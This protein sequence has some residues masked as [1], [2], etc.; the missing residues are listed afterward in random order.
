MEKENIKKLFDRLL[1]QFPNPRCELEYINEYTLM[2]SIILS[3]QATDRGVNKATAPLY[4]KVKT[5]EQMLALGLD[6]LR[7]YVKSINY[8]KTL[9]P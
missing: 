6:G 4:E 3:A 9:M 2:V 1:V 7:E 5:P 8:Y